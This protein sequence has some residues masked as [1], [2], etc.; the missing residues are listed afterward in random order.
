MLSKNEKGKKNRQPIIF[1]HPK[2]LKSDTLSSF[3]HCWSD[4]LLVRVCVIIL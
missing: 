4:F 2:A 3:G 1:F